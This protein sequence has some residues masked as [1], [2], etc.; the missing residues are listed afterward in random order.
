MGL[1]ED[2]AE[3]S[4]AV[5]AEVD[6]DAAWE[7][8]SELVA[9]VCGKHSG[10]YPN[11]SGVFCTRPP[12]AEGT[13]CSTVRDDTVWAWIAGVGWSSLRSRQLREQRYPTP[14]AFAAAAQTARATLEEDL[15][16]ALAEHQRMLARY[17]R[18]TP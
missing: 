1:P 6:V 14:A 2:I 10:R 3:W 18:S 12:H 17:A 7:K 16:V 15:A 8:F 9:T 4:A 13:A 5:D 11:P